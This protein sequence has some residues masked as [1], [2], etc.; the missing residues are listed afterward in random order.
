[1]NE[2]TRK[3]AVALKTQIGAAQGDS[4]H[5]ALLR[6]VVKLKTTLSFT[7]AAV[8]LAAYFG[9]IMVIA[10]KPRWLVV[11]L[12]GNTL[13]TTGLVAAV[14]L[15]AFSAVSAGIYVYIANRKI[16]PLVKAINN[17]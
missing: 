16:D 3:E 17:V 13:I 11:R 2:V 15:F 9:Y 12:T 10:F 4:S 8:T 14:G 6:R 7:M 5:P 1:L